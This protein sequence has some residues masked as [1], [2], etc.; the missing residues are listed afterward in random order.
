VN[1]FETST[2][3]GEWIASLQRRIRLNHEGHEERFSQKNSQYRRLWQTVIL[4]Q[5]QPVLGYL[6]VE[7]VIKAHQQAYY[8]LLGEADNQA[9][10]TA[11]VEFLLEAI[12]HALMD[13]TTQ[14][15]NHKT[16][17]DL[18]EKI[19]QALKANPHLTQKQLA[20]HCGITAD[21]IK[22]HLTK[23]KQANKLQRVGATKG[24]YWQVK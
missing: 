11:F 3:P 21:G 14:E 13:A 4:S 19:L 1:C 24:G 10:C 9:D 5:W 7:T 12:N 23:L 22:Y 20:K 8:D 16:T 17:Q 6:P 15:T 18:P 2:R